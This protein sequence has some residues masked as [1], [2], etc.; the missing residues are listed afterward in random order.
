MDFP[1]AVRGDKEDTEAGSKQADAP[2]PPPPWKP[3]VKHLISDIGD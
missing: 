2:P 3:S 1:G